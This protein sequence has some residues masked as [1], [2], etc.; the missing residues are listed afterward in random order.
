MEYIY[1]C[2]KRFLFVYLIFATTL[3]GGININAT[4]ASTL[5]ISDYSELTTLKEGQAFFVR[6]IISSNFKLTEVSLSITTNKG[7]IEYSATST[8]N[9]TK[10]DI[11]ALDANIRFDLIKS[12]KYIFKVNAKDSSGE[13]KELLKQKFTVSG[14]NSNSIQVVGVNKLERINKGEDYKVEGLLSSENAIT[15]VTASILDGMTGMVQYK[16]S[17]SPNA[18]LYDIS[19]L[20][21]ALYFNKLPI[22]SYVFQVSAM[23][24]GGVNEIIVNQ[25]FQVVKESEPAKKSVVQWLDNC[26]K[27]LN[28][29]VTKKFSYGVA[30]PSYIGTATTNQKT[31][32]AAYVSWCLWRN[33]FVKNVTD[34]NQF[35]QGAAAYVNQLGWKMNTDMNNIKAGDIVYYSQRNITDANRK[36]FIEWLKSH[37]PNQATSGKHVDICYNPENMQF[38]SAGSESYIK[39]GKIATYS[40]TY[41]QKHFICSFRYPQ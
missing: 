41:L 38:L 21:S 22:G 24:S 2:F 1:R 6:G 37:G 29:Y 15:N 5:S 33:G 25:D 28:Y 13:E 20:D 11:S 39:T 7:E 26:K 36:Q 27:A 35:A 16:K 17:V 34:T 23:D 8:P 32:C 4:K 18:N 31:N 10:Y 3:S 19:K 14:E 30:M 12:G 9:K 40:S